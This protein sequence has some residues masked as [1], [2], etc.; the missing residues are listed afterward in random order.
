MAM[1]CSCVMHNEMLNSCSWPFSILVVELVAILWRISDEENVDVEIDEDLT[2][3]ND[4]A[5]VFTLFD[6]FSFCACFFA[7]RP[8][9]RIPAYVVDGR[10]LKTVVVGE[11]FNDS[12]VARFFPDHSSKFC[13]GGRLAN[14]S[15]SD[16]DASECTN[17]QVGEGKGGMCRK[18]EQLRR[19][20]M[21]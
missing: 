11:D 16:V 17:L 21:E 6:F 1:A 8:Y 15:I 14:S 9:G 18:F 10:R 2:L 13:S 4:N 3:S 20:V 19:L 5:L 7:D 12:R